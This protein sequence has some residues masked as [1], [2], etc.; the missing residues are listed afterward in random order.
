MPITIT[1]KCPPLN[2]AE[3]ITNGVIG[4]IVGFD[5]SSL[6]PAFSISEEVEGVVHHRLNQLP[7]M[8]YIKVQGNENILV[9]GFPPGI[10]GIP[11]TKYAVQIDLPNPNGRAKSFSMTVWAFNMVCAYAVTPE[12]VQGQTIP[13]GV[14]ITHLERPSFGMPKASL[15]VAF[16]RIEQL[17]KLLLVTELTREYVD[18]FTP[19]EETVNEMSRLQKM[20]SFPEYAT[21]FQREEFSL[22]LEAEERMAKRCNE[23][24]QQEGR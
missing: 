13:D 2:K 9:D 4:H 22:W 3:V 24:R 6:D 10:I 19:N 14:I 5:L 20:V 8:I 16:S 1:R 12:K 11:A 17:N 18:R 15:Y 23:K 21:A 7:E